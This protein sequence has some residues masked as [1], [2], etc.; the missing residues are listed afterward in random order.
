[1]VELGSFFPRE[2]LA[3]NT[4][5][6]LSVQGL[7]QSIK[8]GFVVDVN[9]IPKEGLS[10]LLLLFIIVVFFELEAVQE[11]LLEVFE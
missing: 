9:R 11:G 1:M 6:S 10:L 7:I 3:P 2:R 4:K 5:W 8:D